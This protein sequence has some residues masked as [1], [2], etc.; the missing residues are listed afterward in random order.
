RVRTRCLFHPHQAQRLRWLG[1]PLLPPGA[2]LLLEVLAPPPPPL[3][4]AHEQGHG[5][6]PRY[7]GSRFAPALV[8]RQP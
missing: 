2:L 3:H 4:R 8:P 1:P 5:L 7:Q 6:R